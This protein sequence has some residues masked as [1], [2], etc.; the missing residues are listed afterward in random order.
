MQLCR[1]AA[2]MTRDPT[3][4]KLCATPAPLMRRLRMPETQPLPTYSSRCPQGSREVDGIV[5][6]VDGPAADQL[7]QYI[8]ATKTTQALPPRRHGLTL[9]ANLFLAY[10][11]EDYDFLYFVTDH[12]ITGG[13]T[14]AQYE[15]VN[16]R[17]IPG[18]TLEMEVQASGY[19]TAGRLKGVIGV[20]YRPVIF[21]PIAHETL[22]YWANFLDPQF[23][24]GQAAGD[25]HWGLASV[26]GVLGGFDAISL[27]C[28]TPAN[29]APPA[30]TALPGGRTRYVVN[31][32]YPN[33]NTGRGLPYAPLE[34]YLMGLLPGSDVPAHFQVFDH[35]AIDE[36]MRGADS[37]VV[38][39]Q[40]L[41][42]V[43]F[44]NIVARHG[45]VPQL[46]QDKRSFRAAFVVISAQPASADVLSDVAKWA[47]GFGHRVKINGWPS[48]EDAASG[49]ASMDTLLGG[50][51]VASDHVP[52]ER[53][54][55][56][57]D[58]L[59][60]NCPRS[61]L[62]CYEYLPPLCALSGAVARDQACAAPFACAPGLECMS[63]ASNAYSCEPYCDP[64]TIASDKAC[65][66]LCPG[67][68]FDV[69]D[70][71]GNTVSAA[72]KPP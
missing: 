59:K 49:L 35:G 47:A 56:S 18:G 9:P 66:M 33:D 71:T 29:A 36:S 44:A 24:F 60:Q 19:R 48:F 55:L 32:F 12:V 72:C 58:V 38:E 51:R 37:V 61:E 53:G 22:H 8:L 34:L 42:S 10:Y 2:T 62:G 7:E 3:P 31:A 13:T 67:N 63:G 16:R 28:E 26:N 52:Q 40:G 1:A 14:I 6:L 46:P 43:D 21:P 17:A 25:P 41:K 15:D 69:Q 50:R 68:E 4:E 65:A 30:C 20:R 23:G 54:E 45:N 11:P 39:A 27:R 57:C 70:K 5:N 64:S